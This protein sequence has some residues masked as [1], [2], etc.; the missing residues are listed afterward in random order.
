MADISKININGILY[1]IKDTVARQ[2]LLNS[3]G[4]II[5]SSAADTPEGVTWSDGTTTI[6]G[7]EIPGAPAL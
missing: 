2:S 1:D 5:C 3:G 6:T 7:E 4:W